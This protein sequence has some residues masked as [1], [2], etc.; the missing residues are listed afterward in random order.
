MAGRPDLPV[1][2]RRAPLARTL[3]TPAALAAALLV[4][5]TAFTHAD[6]LSGRTTPAY[7]DIATT[8]RPARALAARLGAARLDPF[9][10]FGQAYRGNPNLVLAYPFPRNP[11]FLGLHLLLHLGLG[12]LGAFLFLRTEVKSRDAALT[13]AFAFGLSGYV[14]S[15]AAFLN[16]TTT[17][18][19]MPWTLLAVQ[20]GRAAATRADLLRAGGLALVACSLLVLGGEPALAGLALLLAF[21]LAARGPAGARRGGLLALFGGGLAAAVVVSPWLLEVVRASAF[22]ARRSRGFSWNEFAAVGFHPLRLLETPFPLAFGDPTRLLS[23]AF[24]GFAVT[25]GNPPYHA[26]L[27]FGVVP[28][29]LA[30]VFAC[31]ARRNEGHFW[32]GVA[33]LALLASFTPWLPGARALYE[34][35]PAVHVLRY[36]VKALL[37]VTLALSVLAALGVD[38]LLVEGALPRFRRRA[39]GFLFALG[40]V[41]AALAVAGRLFPGRVRDLLLSGWDPSWLSDP[42]VVLAPVVQRLPGQAALA[43]ASLI[44]LALLLL[45]GIGDPRGAFFLFG[46]TALSLL[47]WSPRTIPRVPSAL[48]ETPSPLVARAAALGGRVFERAAKDF[49]AVRR[50]VAGRVSGDDLLD[51]ASAQVRQGWALSGAPHGLS[52]AWDPDPD[53]SYTIL[54]R[55]AHDVLRQRSWERRVKWLRAGAVRSVIAS[56]VPAETPGLLPVF[57]EASAGVPATLWRLTAPLPGVRRQSRVVA[58]GSISETVTVFERDDFEP[59]TDVVVYGKEAAALASGDRDSSAE[60]RVTEESPDRLVIETSGARPAVL[61][62]DRSFTPRVVARVNGSPATPLVADLHLIG[63]PVPAGLSRVVVDL[64]P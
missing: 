53:G 63:V 3:L 47:A 58:S 1:S 26:S 10:S 21:A 2:E 49:D 4:A 41:L 37:P 18:A 11:R 31:S 20:R 23:G 59:A 9:A 51:L 57:V 35:M 29:A 32:I 27:S 36:P 60:A 43:A 25:Q 48:Y 34:A 28:L 15:S 7:R 44:V 17:I 46:A 12:L 6:L 52:Y 45:R 64:A 22:A 54:T 42:R 62:V 38:R 40:G 55:Y 30:L 13:G 24:W 50:G 14:L 16:A 56:D 39:A 19:W 5:S 61:H 33:L 8:Q